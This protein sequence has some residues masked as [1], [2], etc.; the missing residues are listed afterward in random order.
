MR[1]V[2]STIAIPVLAVAGA[3]ANDAAHTTVSPFVWCVYQ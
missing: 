2:L 1:F 3:A